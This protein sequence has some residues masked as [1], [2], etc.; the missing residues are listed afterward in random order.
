[1]AYEETRNWMLDR[2]P[3]GATAVEIGVWRGDFSARILERAHPKLL[4]LIDP[5]AARPDGVHAQSIYGRSS[6]DNMDGIYAEVQQRFASEVAEGQVQIHRA[7]S[8][9]AMARFAPDS[10]DYV[11]IDG[12]HAFDAVSVDL[13]LSFQRV[14]PGGLICL[15]DHMMG[16]WWGDGI[17]RAV[18]TFLGAH[19]ER[20]HLQF[21][22]DWQVVIRK[23]DNA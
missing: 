10:L 8:A 21:V 11:Y 3:N 13:E 16:K 17:V 4:H 5:W 9:K 6:Q 14:R 20:L 18:N 7:T 22:G 1:M 23:R 15:D 19:P 12:D 2:L